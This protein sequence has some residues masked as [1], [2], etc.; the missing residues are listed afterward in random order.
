MI[1]E[2]LAKSMFAA[3]WQTVNLQKIGRR[4]RERR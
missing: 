1:G 3:D 2:D 4:K